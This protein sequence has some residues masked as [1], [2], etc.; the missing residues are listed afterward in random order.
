M[1]IR[2]KP[3]KI[4]IILL[5]TALMLNN[6]SA[7]DI[8]IEQGI[9]NPIP[10]AIV[11]FG[12][13]QASLAPIDLS[14][15]IVSDLERSARFEAMDFK[16]LPQQPSEF[17]NINFKD[18]RLLGM[19]NLVIG[20]LIQTSTGDYEVEFRLIDVYKEKQIAGFRLPS[21]EAQL[22]TTAHELSDIIYKKLVGVRGAFATRIAYI[23]VNK[24]REGIKTF[25]LQIADADGHNPQVL[26]ESPEPLLSPSWSPDGKRL[27]YVSFEGKNSAIFVQDIKT[28]KRDKVAANRGINSAPSWSPDGSRLAMTLSK[29][30]NTEIYIMHLASNS[31]QRI[32]KNKAID[33]EPNWSS[34]GKKLAFTSD[35][36]GSPQIYE[37]SVLGGSKAKRLT[38]EGAYNARPRYSADG[39]SLIMVTGEKGIYRIAILDL[40]NGFFDILTKSR[41]DESPSF[42]PND[43]M[44]I[45]TTTGA[46]GTAL[47][48]VSADGQVHQRLELQDGEVREPAWGPFLPR[49]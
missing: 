17:Q 12:W 46:R 35:R 9:E 22:R 32:T 5:V 44:I 45:Y 14:E 40:R 7:L 30:G 38:F 37:I 4:R 25:A 3:G 2:M 49:R 13:S 48:A 21:T 39:K 43:H 26:L 42:A 47:A 23:T 19:E 11:P 41:L 33:T 18:W 16:D 29:D 36:G 8:T 24:N 28:G 15:I 34:D 20:Q 31:L 6:A 27:A 1:T 10:V